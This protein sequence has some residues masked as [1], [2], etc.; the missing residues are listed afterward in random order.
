MAC[1]FAVCRSSRSDSVFVP[2]SVS[3][4]TNGDMITP[5]AFW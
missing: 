4:A 5:V 1:A 3:H 2:C